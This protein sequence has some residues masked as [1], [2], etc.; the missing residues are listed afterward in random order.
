MYIC[1]LLKHK[2]YKTMTKKFLAWVIAV[3]TLL[4]LASCGSG[5]DC[6]FAQAETQAN[7]ETTA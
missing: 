3:L 2:N 7:I 4:V 1:N 5:C 6:A